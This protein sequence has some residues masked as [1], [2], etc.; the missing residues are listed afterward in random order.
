MSWGDTRSTP[1]TTDAY[2]N[3]KFWDKKEK[4]DKEKCKKKNSKKSSK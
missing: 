4:E 3:N 2:R 1:P